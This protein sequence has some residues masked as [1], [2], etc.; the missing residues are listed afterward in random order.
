MP[1]TAAAVTDHQRHR[2][3]VLGVASVA[4]FMVA[5]DLLVVTT[6]LD[7]VRRDLAVSTT[8]L[9]WTVTAYGVSFAALLMTGA[10][11][12]DHFG[13]RRMLV[14]GLLVFAAG[15]VGA[16][17]ST[18][19]GPLIAAR[20][21][22]G[23]GGAIILP[24]G[25]TIVTTAFPPARRGSAIGVLEGVTGLA[26]IAGPLIG[27]AV[28]HWLPWYWIFWINV[29]IALA[30]IPV[31]LVVVE[32]SFGDGERFDIIGLALVST[33]A[34]AFVWA[35]SRG[36]DIGWSSPQTAVALAIA[37][38]G[39]LGF[40]AWERRTS[41]PMLPPRLFRSSAFTI[42][43]ATAFLVAGSLYIAVYFM[44]QYLR[45]VLGYDSFETGV[46]LLPWTATLLVVAPLAGALADRVGPRPVLSAGLLIQAL[47]M[48]WIAW[49]AHVGGSYAALVGPLVLTGIGTSAA[50]PVTQ[51]VALGA[52]ADP[53]I[54]K[55]AGTNNMLQELGGA[56][57]IAVGVAAFAAVGGTER[58][59]VFA[60]GFVT[61]ISVAAVLAACAC[62]LSLA[63]PRPGGGRTP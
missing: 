16:A 14:A 53:D 47:G 11:L 24:V 42:G 50:L 60:A 39:A 4:S 21:V 63:L 55:A 27:G 37:T 46:R 2:G 19:L 59:D 23:V 57:G 5:L 10:A 32:E 33:A 25:L 29:P 56:F 6:S 8:D 3:V 7:V 13:R 41:E 38:A 35:L 18:G 26:V 49:T 62:A 31:V 51:A 30:A 12:G 44:A 45:G 28:A 52:V 20:V 48:A 58:A 34:T 1:A 61:A 43:V 9:Q 54:G 15:S 36:N 17:L 22:Q 40:A